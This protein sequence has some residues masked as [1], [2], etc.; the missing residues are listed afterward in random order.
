MTDPRVVVLQQRLEAHIEDFN[1]H[2]KEEYERWE[3]LMKITE[4]NAKAIRDLS[5]ST[6]DLISAWRAATGAVKVGSALGNFIKWL[7]G[8][9]VVGAAIAW[10]IK[11]L[12]TGG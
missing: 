11:H 2:K 7:S 6:K 8:F 12:N 9:A 3:R 4:A 1:E 10:L 5:E